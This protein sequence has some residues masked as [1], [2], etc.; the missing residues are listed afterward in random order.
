[1]LFYQTI[2]KLGKFNE[3]FVAIAKKLGIAKKEDPTI[4][5]GS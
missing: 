5:D 4:M 3:Y 1:M 2:L